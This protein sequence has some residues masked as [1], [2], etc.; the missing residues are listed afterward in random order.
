MLH[1]IAIA[2]ADDPDDRWDFYFCRVDDGP[3]SITL[4]LRYADEKPALD[5]LYWVSITMRDRG[6]HDMGTA[7][8]AEELYAM[9]DRFIASARAAGFLQVGRLRN[10]SVWQVTFY[11][12][13]GRAKQLGELV[14]EHGFGNRKLAFDSKPDRDWSY[15]DEF[16][17][18]SAERVQWMQDRDVVSALESHGDVHATPRRVDH[19]IYLPS[20]KARE[21]FIED[22]GREGFSV[23]ASVPARRRTHAVRVFRT[24]PVELEHIHDVVMTLVELAEKHDGEYDGW[25]TFVEKT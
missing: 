23:E 15:Y 6:E 5:T 25:E 9:E 16:L 18:P 20:K 24:D 8:E 12:Q 17:Y 7:A 2:M 1:A 3:A 4:N 11:G 10:N 22:V 13:A 21:A 14:R 19:W